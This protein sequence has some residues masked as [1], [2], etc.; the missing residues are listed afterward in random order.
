MLERKRVLIADDHPIYLLG[1]RALL[2]T[3]S[4]HYHVIDEAATT[5]ELIAKLE[6]ESVD[7]LVTDFSM[8]GVKYNDGLALIQLLKR[9]WPKLAI[10]V[11]TMISN[12]AVQS[13]LLRL[14]VRAVLNKESLARD[15]LKTIKSV[16][17]PLVSSITR[18]KNDEAIS[19]TSIKLTPK[20]NEILRLLLRGMTVNEI[21][22]RLRRTKQTVSAQKNSAM[23]KLG[24]TSEYELYQY[25][26]QLGLLS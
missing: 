22:C 15:L 19:H 25:V 16:S 7:I 4:E 18:A 21:S 1:L 5:D 24:V 9:R 3:V 13:S 20:E 2:E 23:R 8:P 17:S 12:P 14:G 11:V 10:V 26:Q 6:S